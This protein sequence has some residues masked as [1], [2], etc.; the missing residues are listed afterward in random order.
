MNEIVFEP[1]ASVSEGVRL[2]LLAPPAML[3][4]M[5]VIPTLSEIARASE[6]SAE[7]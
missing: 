1:T 7:A 4:L 5:V 2:L 3:V 6:D